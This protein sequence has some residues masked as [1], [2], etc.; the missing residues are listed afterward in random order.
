VL[1]NANVLTYFPPPFLSFKELKLSLWG[2]AEDC[3]EIKENKKL[4]NRRT[5]NIW[6]LFN[7]KISLSLRGNFVY[8]IG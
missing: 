8:P 4:S 6:Q 7:S 1:K 3:Q 5:C 2:G